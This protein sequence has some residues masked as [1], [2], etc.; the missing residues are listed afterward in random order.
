[1]WT[2]YTRIS[3][4]QSPEGKKYMSANRDTNYAFRQ[5]QTHKDINSPNLVHKLNRI[6][7]KTTGFPTSN[8]S[9]L[10]QDKLILKFLWKNKQA[11]TSQENSKESS[12]GTLATWRASILIN[13]QWSNSMALAKRWGREGTGPFLPML[14]VGVKTGLTP[15]KTLWQYLLKLHVGIPYDMRL[16]HLGMDSTKMCNL[17]TKKLHNRMFIS[18]LFIIAPN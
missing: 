11:K 2:T 17:L 4:K 6:A 10:T 1:M 12:R 18:E 9:T 8:P 14:L 5:F 7:I 3:L 15:L 16:S 13:P